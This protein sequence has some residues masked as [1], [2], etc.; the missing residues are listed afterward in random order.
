L[1]AGDRAHSAR[2]LRSFAQPGVDVEEVIDLHEMLDTAVT[3]SMPQLGARIQIQRS[4]GG[5]VVLAGISRRL[6]QVFVNLIGNAA[7]AI[8][9]RGTIRLRTAASAHGVEVTIVD[10][11]CGIP[12]FVQARLFEPFVTTKGPSSGAGLGLFVC[13]NVVR[14]HGGEIEIESEPGRGT[15]VRVRLPRAESPR[16]VSP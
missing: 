7:Q 1:P 6:T 3:L 16:E 2:D 11:G 14:Q 12:E 4:Y 5:Q 10:D 15:T 9:D 8:A 13:R